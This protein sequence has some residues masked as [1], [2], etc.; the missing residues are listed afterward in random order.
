MDEILATYEGYKRAREARFA[1]LKDN[2]ALAW[3][4]SEEYRNLE[5][6]ESRWKAKFVSAVE[7]SEYEPVFRTYKYA[8]D[9]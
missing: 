8:S 5:R 3:I 1:W 6:E 7:D 2:H 9:N 4:H